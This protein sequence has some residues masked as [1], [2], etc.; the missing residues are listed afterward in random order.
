MSQE[1]SG[2]QRE[3]LRELRALGG[4]RYMVDPWFHAKVETVRRVILATCQGA[5]E[6]QAFET[7]L[8]TMAAIEIKGLES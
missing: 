6:N 4:R 1:L 2:A 7:A 8:V 5:S 3:E